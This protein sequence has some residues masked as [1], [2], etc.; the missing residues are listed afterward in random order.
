MLALI[1]SFVAIIVGYAV[2][3][4]LSYA[5]FRFTGHAPHEAA[6]PLFKMAS[7]ASGV[8]FAF[9]GGYVAGWI[10]RTHPLAHGVAVAGILALG[11][12]VSLAA[13]YGHGAIWSQVSALT[14]MV[15]SAVLGGWLRAPASTSPL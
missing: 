5:L 14:L 11:A 6:S 8:I 3:A 2:F 1:R 4:S 7:I 12:A 15:P 10:G 13:T 9:M